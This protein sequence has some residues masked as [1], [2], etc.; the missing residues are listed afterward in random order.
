MYMYAYVYVYVRTCVCVC[1]YYVRVDIIYKWLL[2]N[3]NFSFPL[4]G[5]GNIPMCSC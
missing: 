5:L 2:N 3:N 4:L 1:A